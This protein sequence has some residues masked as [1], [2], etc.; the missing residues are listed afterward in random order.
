M[1]VTGTA[2]APPEVPLQEAILGSCW[3]SERSLSAALRSFQRLMPGTPADRE[4]SCT[5]RLT[6]SYSDNEH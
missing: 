3:P 1:Q 2:F 5:T 4:S 6:Q